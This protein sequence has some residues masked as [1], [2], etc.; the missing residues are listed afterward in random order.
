MNTRKIVRIVV[1]VI[2]VSLFVGMLLAYIRTPPV[3]GPATPTATPAPTETAKPA[4]AMTPEPTATA[5]PTSTPW[6]YF[7]PRVGLEQVRAVADDGKIWVSLPYCDTRQEGRVITTT[8]VACVYPA[9]SEPRSYRGGITYLDGFIAASVCSP[10]PQPT[11][12]VGYKDERQAQIE[13]WILADSSAVENA[14]F[15]I[16]PPT[17]AVILVVRPTTTATPPP[18]ETPAP[19]QTPTLM[20]TTTPTPTLPPG[21]VD[22]VGRLVQQVEYKDEIFR[23]YLCTEREGPEEQTIFKVV[24]LLPSGQSIGVVPIGVGEVATFYTGVQNPFRVR[25]VACGTSYCMEVGEH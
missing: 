2:V 13:L 14:K 5:T 6:Q 3:P 10:C 4:T 1:L 24:W 17:W 22:C 12:M 8:G 9:L 20:P 18:T 25:V 16:K 19:T 15:G 23:L 21:F 11:F 7:L